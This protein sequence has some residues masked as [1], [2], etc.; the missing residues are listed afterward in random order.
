M[1]AREKPSCFRHSDKKHKL[2]WVKRCK[3]L[4]SFE[5]RCE[6]DGFQVSETQYLSGPA[7]SLYVDFS[8]Y[9]R[10]FGLRCT[11]LQGCGTFPNSTYYKVNSKVEPED[12]D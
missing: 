10:A 11:H 7:I 3:I 8:D 2:K 5:V 12:R 6:G 1:L 4:S 9:I